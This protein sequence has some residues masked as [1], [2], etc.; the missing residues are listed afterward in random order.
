MSNPHERLQHH[1]TGAIE[2]GEAVAIVE[3]PAITTLGA[4]RLSSG[5][6][7]VRPYGHCG[8]CGWIGGKPWQV[9]YLTAR[10]VAKRR[11]PIEVSP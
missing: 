7:A 11:I 6:Y 8:T 2:R 5:H 9:E 1:V 4:V 10:Q 3:E